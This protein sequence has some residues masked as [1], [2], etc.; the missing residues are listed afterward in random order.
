MGVR[1]GLE[2]G[3]GEVEGEV[4]VRVMVQDETRARIHFHQMTILN[5]AELKVIYISWSPAP[6]QD[7]ISAC[8][9]AASDKG[10]GWRKE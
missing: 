6:W 9:L 4:R 3:P 1:H 2:K 5:D 7:K 8:T 10:Q